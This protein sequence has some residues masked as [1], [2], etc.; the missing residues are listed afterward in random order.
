MIVEI[1]GTLITVRMRDNYYVL[2]LISD[3]PTVSGFLDKVTLGVNAVCCN[4]ECGSSY[5]YTISIVAQNS[6]VVIRRWQAIAHDE[7]KDII[8][9]NMVLRLTRAQ[10]A[11]ICKAVKLRGEK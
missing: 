1:D 7:S 4:S 10:Y 8:E 9:N 11:K 3:Y 5:G 2:S 6:T